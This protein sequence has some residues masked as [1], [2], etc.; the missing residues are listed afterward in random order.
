MEDFLNHE[1]FK[2][3]SSSSRDSANSL[4]LKAMD[5]RPRRRKSLYARSSHRGSASGS[6]GGN[7]QALSL[8]SSANDRRS[9]LKQEPPL[10]PDT[11]PSTSALRRHSSVSEVL[12]G[13]IMQFV[14]QSQKA[15]EFLS[16]EPVIPVVEISER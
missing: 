6:S 2:S 5:G 4:F 14:S 8:A 16:S 10:E 3:D 15:Y 7:P 1:D 11:L 9:S 12:L 13:P